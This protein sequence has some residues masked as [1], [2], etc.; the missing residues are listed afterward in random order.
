MGYAFFP[1]GQAA[2][3]GSVIA[4]KKLLENDKLRVTIAGNGELSGVYDKVHD[5]EVLSGRGN[6]LTVFI[7]KCVHE[8]AWNLEKNYQKK[9]WNLDSADS[10]EVLEQNTV[11]GVVRVVRTFHKSTITQDIILWADSDRVDFDTTVDWHESDKMLKA[12]FPVNVLNTHASFEIAHGAIQRPTHRNNSY[13][14]AKYEQCA[15]KW[16][17]LSEG[18]YGV[19]ILNDCKYGYDIEDNRMRLTLMR[20]PTCPDTVGDHGVNT[21]VYSLYPHAG[22][23][24]S[25]ETVQQALVLNVPL[26]GVVLQKQAGTAPAARSFVSADRDDIIVDAFKQAQDDNGCILRLYESAQKRGTVTVHV[27]LP[28]TRVTECNLMEENEQEIPVENGTFR[29]AVHPFEVKT[30]RLQ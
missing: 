11:R 10:I 5:R 16:A 4:T 25:S 12:A 20:A 21:F 24:Q 26:I 15:H 3:T 13:D 2:D 28:F 29:F 30:F 1:F 22:T 23:W 18:D 7:D 14:A 19:S 27:D 9:Y 17:D 6:M 8:T